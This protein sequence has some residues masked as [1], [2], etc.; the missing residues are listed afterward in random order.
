ME[1]GHISFCYQLNNALNSHSNN[2]IF[3]TTDE[4]PIFA[5]H[6]VN[7]FENRCN[8]VLIEAIIKP[9]DSV[10]VPQDNNIRK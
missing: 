1:Y 2:R 3:E 8:L 6:S 9:N 7:I 10:A 5:A 4:Y